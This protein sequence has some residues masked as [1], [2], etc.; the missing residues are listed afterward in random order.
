VP[1]TAGPRHTYMRMAIGRSFSSGPDDAM[2]ASYY[3]TVSIADLG[4]ADPV[5]GGN[6]ALRS[7]SPHFDRE[8]TSLDSLWLEWKLN[9]A[10]GVCKGVYK[11][12]AGRTTAAAPLQLRIVP[13]NEGLRLLFKHPHPTIVTR[14]VPVVSRRG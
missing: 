12:G 1:G 10:G 5:K 14:M 3:A 7:Q 13:S 8:T 4:C 2:L 11:A 9:I 6:L